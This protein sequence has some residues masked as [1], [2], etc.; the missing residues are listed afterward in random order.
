MGVNAALSTLK[1]RDLF[2]PLSLVVVLGLFLARK[3]CSSV[4][5]FRRGDI[6]PALDRRDLEDDR[7]RFRFFAGVG[8][9][10]LTTSF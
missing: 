8:N 9:R 5:D 6:C 3:A 1:V 2:K 7:R 10:I 4:E